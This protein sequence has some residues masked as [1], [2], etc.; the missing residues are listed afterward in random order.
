MRKFQALT[1]PSLIKAMKKA[2]FATKDDLAGFATKKDLIGFATKDDLA[3][4]A[5]KKDLSK[6]TT[7]DDLKELR[8]QIRDDQ[9]EARAEFFQKMTIPAINEANSKLETKLT[10][11]IE[12]VE[13]NLKQEID[14]LKAELSETPSRIDLEKIQKQVT[15]LG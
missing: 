4:F 13:S 1:V 8:Q 3:G 2:G 5:T 14:G 6:F 12:S 15:T 10:E 9:D 7:K 11:R